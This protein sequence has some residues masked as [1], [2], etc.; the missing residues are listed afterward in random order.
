VTFKEQ[1]TA[2][3]PVFVNPDEFADTIDIDGEAVSC[4]LDDQESPAAF[5]GVATQ[6]STLYA[7]TSSFYK[8]PVVRQRVKVNDR[9]ADITKVVDDQG[10]LIISLRWWNS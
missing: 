2:D 5:D 4:V 6:E 7:L 3:L 9:Q 10:I 8:M 1:L